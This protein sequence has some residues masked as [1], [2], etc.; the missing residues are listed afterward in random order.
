M[1]QLGLETK[2]LNQELVNATIARLKQAK[3]V[4]PT[5][6]QLQDPSSIPH[7]IIEMLKGVSPDQAQPLNL[8]RVHW[9]NDLETGGLTGVPEHVILP[10]ALTGVD[11]PIVVLFGDTFPMISAHKVLPAYACLA[12]RLVTG[13]FDPGYHRAVWPST[14]N[15]CRGGVAISRI[16]GCNSVAVLPEGMSRERFTWLEEWVVDRD[17]IIR[18]PGTESNVKEIYD[19]CAEL[20]ADERNVIFNQFSEFGNYLGHYLVTGAALE[21]VFETIQGATPD[22]RLAAFVGA[23]GSAG[24]LA[25]GD[26]LKDRFG[27][28][29]AAAEPVECPTLACNGYGEHNI[30]GI[31]DKHVPYIHNVMNTDFIIGVSDKSSDALNVLFNTISGRDY[32]TGRK[33]L[34]QEFTDKILNRMGLSSSA[35]ILAAIKLARHQ[36]LG[37]NDV[38]MTIATDGG[39]MYQTE[40]QK[41]LEQ[42]F[43]GRFDQLDAAEV[44]GQ[45]IAGQGSDEVAELS[46]RDRD[47][48]FNLGYY[49]WVEQQ[50]VAL[51]DFDKRRDQAFWR[52][53]TELAPIWDRM[54]EDVNSAA[55]VFSASP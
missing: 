19:K 33:G 49:T 40:K 24:T 15:Y 51:A 45:H 44:F 3:V 16:L 28:K 18:T 26:Y 52:Q 31:G 25:A 12:P 55:G 14:G 11:S 29:I 9:H 38:L 54:I 47:R 42:D 39:S 23:T 5:F 22:L 7:S 34:D 20:D 48:I 41:T 50:G 36:K 53:L 37:P 4:L 13:Q 46:L 32:L 1:I 30:Q 43:S 6:S 8:F 35:N 21:K 10:S 17:D 27:S 2:I